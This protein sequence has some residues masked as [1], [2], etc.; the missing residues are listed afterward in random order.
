MAVAGV[1]VVADRL[2]AAAFG[3]DAFLGLLDGITAVATL[4]NMPHTVAGVT[5]IVVNVEA[6]LGFL[7]GVVT[8]VALP[9]GG[10][11]CSP[12]LVWFPSPQRQA[13]N[14]RVGRYLV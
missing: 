3:M 2:S 10:R 13:S 4:P 5:A 7:D 9:A 8:M 12:T 11:T 6:F 14:R 1:G